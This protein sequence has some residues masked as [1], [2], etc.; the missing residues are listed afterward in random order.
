[1]TVVVDDE[2][3]DGINNVNDDQTNLTKLAKAR[4]PSLRLSNSKYYQTALGHPGPM[5][6]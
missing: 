5:R 6:K 3:A 2:V 4:F 1:M